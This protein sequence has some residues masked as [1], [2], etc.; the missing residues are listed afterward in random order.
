MDI[1]SGENVHN[2]YLILRGLCDTPKFK[3]LKSFLLHLISQDAVEMGK[4]SFLSTLG[5]LELLSKLYDQ[6]Y[7]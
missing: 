4:A 6:G 1:F 2:F 3:N 5:A 7:L